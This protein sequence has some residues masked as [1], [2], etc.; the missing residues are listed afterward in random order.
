[1]RLCV[2]LQI[3]KPVLSVTK[4]IS[5]VRDEDRRQSCTYATLSPV[6]F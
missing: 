6:L 5:T 4:K 3:A 2:F 1:M